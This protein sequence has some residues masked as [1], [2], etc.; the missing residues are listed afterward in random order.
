MS[1]YETLMARDGHA[2]NAYIAK[3][4]GTPHGGIVVIQEIFGLTRFVRGVTDSFAAAGYLAVAPALFDRVRRDI[5]LGY[6][7]EEVEQGHGYSMRIDAARSLLDVGAAASFARHAGKVAVVGFC[8]GGRLAWQ[9][10]CDVRIDAAVSY[11]GARISQHLTRTPACPMMFHVG[12]HDES[13]PASEIA[14]V[15]AAFPSGIFHLYENCGHAF[16]NPDRPE[17]YNME[18][19]AVARQRTDAFLSTVLG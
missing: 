1:Q 3:P 18:A 19:A 11:Y 17:R 16:A 7:R 8:W 2:F 15:R 10:A 9:A 6:S 5:Q 14:K 13:I 4:S 12:D